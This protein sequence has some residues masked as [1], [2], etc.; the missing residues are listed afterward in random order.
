MTIPADP[1]RTL[2]LALRQPGASYWNWSTSTWIPGPINPVG[3]LLQLQADPQQPDILTATLPAVAV[4]C[5]VLLMTLSASGA[6][7]TV[8]CDSYGPGPTGES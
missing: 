1:T 4:P 7:V 8:A 3:G 6:P 5:V 2:Y